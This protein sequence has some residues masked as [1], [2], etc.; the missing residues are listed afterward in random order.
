MSGAPADPSVNGEATDPSVNGEPTDPSVNGE[1]IN[2]S[3][4]GNFN[5][6]PAHWSKPLN[7]SE[8]TETSQIILN[9]IVN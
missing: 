9:T 4:N 8:S 2:P 1:V 3:V 7:S 5:N 6:K